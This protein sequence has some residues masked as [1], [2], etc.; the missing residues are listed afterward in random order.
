MLFRPGH[1]GGELV[2]ERDVGSDVS[3]QYSLPN[4]LV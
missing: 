1:V 4:L 3:I 2:V